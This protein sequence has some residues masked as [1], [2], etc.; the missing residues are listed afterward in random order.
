MGNDVVWIAALVINVLGFF[1]RIERPV[2]LFNL[3]KRATLSVGIGSR[4]VFTTSFVGLAMTVII[5]AAFKFADRI[6]FAAFFLAIVLIPTFVSLYKLIN[7]AL[8]PQR[9]IRAIAKVVDAVILE[10]GG[11]GSSREMVLM[12]AL[13]PEL[14]L[15]VLPPF[16]Y[17]AGMRL[18]IGAGVSV[19]YRIGCF[20]SVYRFSFDIGL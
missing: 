3:T 14:G 4:A 8:P 16:P 18:A 10:E 2:W 20:G 15:R 12:S 11:E 7:A 1:I 5:I 6:P 9:K 19:F 17:P 13:L